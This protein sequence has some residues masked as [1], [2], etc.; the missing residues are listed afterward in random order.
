M[1]AGLLIAFAGR[2][3]GGPEVYEREVVRAMW[4]AAPQHEFHLYCLDRRAP[5]VIG[6]QDERVV[7]H[8]LQPSVRAVS[9]V[10]SLPLAMH[11]PR[12]D[13]FH[14]PIITPP[15]FPPHTIMALV[16]SSLIRHPEFY[17]PLVRLRLRFLVHRALRKVAR[18][19]CL[20]E[21]IREAVQDHFRLPAER[22][23]VIYPG[24]SSLFRAM[25]H[26][27]Q[28]AHM[29]EKYGVRAPYFLY[30]GRWEHRKN[31]VRIIEAFA[32]FKRESRSEHKLVFSGGRTWAA[33]E[34]DAA[35]ARLGLQNEIV[36][37]GKTA[38]D[39]LPRIYGGADGLVYASLWEGFGMPIVEAMACG[40]P[41]I[42]SNVSAMPE[43]A[44]G[45]ALLVDPHSTE[46]IAGAMQRM[47][48]DDGLRKD[49]RA[50]GLRR[51]QAFGWEITARKILD[52]YRDI[53]S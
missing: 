6:L 28:R 5:E 29:E 38:V 43:T 13:V 32:R 40:T 27:E 15:Y 50:R 42:T 23:P 8:R 36:D 2:N 33:Q 10:T 17:P 9:M 39:E 12:T 31:V 7:Y 48:A 18:V 51:A 47:A 45:A 41:V 11:R 16:C 35:I 20:S 4:A 25:D 46:D 52:V 26:G 14:A 49:L 24:V 3:C 19:I 1:K 30:C 22:L 37:L 34:A 21:H 53:A 44:G